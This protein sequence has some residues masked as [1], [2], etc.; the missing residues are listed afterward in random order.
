MRAPPERAPASP[1]S[2]ALAAGRDDREAS[3]AKA[4]TPG[5]A[6]AVE[7]VGPRVVVAG[8]IRADGADV[9]GPHAAGR[10]QEAGTTR[11]D[12]GVDDRQIRR[13]AAAGA[14][15]AA[16]GKVAGAGAAEVVLDLAAGGGA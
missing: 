10:L 3:V 9:G 6:G 15:T 1:P 2:G 7:R 8:L 14:D 13:R 12:A 5:D 11:A 4:V 16:V